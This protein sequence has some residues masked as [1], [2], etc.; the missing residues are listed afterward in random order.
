MVPTATQII[1]EQ[2][3][4]DLAFL[5]TALSD[6]TRLRILFTLLESELS[7]QAIASQIGMSHSA[8]SHQLASLRLTRIVKAQKR[9]RQVFYALDDQHVR[10]LLLRGF[11]HIHHG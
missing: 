5:F 6:P 11:D 7:V 8:I 9:G 2:Q 4:H 3:A 1:N 10:D